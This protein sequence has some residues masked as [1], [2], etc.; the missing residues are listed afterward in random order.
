MSSL[1]VPYSTWLHV[2]ND[3]KRFIG[4]RSGLEGSKTLQSIFPFYLM[5]RPTQLHF[6]QSLHGQDRSGYSI[7][8]LLVVF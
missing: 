8:L 2:I 6:T 5:M 1:A 4:I 3:T 7:G